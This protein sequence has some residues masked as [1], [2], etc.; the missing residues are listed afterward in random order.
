MT[1]GKP[2]RRLE[3]CESTNDI[4]AQWAV[5]A[6]D[7]AVDG[8]LVTADLQTKGRGRRGRSWDSGSGDNVIMSMVLRDK[9]AADTVWQIGFVCALAI[10]DALL[11]HGV[12]ARIKWPNDVLIDGKKVAGVLVEVPVQS[13]DDGWIAIAGV[14]V[15]VNRAGFTDAAQ[16]LMPPTSLFLETGSTIS[17]GE[18]ADQIAHFVESWEKRRRNGEWLAIV[19]EVRARLA[20]G[21]PLTRGG[22]TGLLRDIGAEGQA[23]V[24]LNCGTFSQWHTVDYEA[25]SNSV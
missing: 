25:G 14:G 11:E 2:Y 20:V 18:L 10:S 3:E 19:E 22:V 12:D 21:V 1:Y 9:T 13:R 5:D 24:E 6:A 23:V 8:A 4:A 7:P 15:N 16:F 17:P